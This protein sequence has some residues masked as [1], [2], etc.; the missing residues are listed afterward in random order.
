MANTRAA[1]STKACSTAIRPMGPRPTTAA[2]LPELISALR[3]P[4][5][6][7]AMPSVISRAWSLVTPS[8]IFAAL[9]S[10]A[11]TRTASACEP[12]SFDD[13]P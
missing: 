2:V 12:C 6:A 7:V 1:P 9:K 5:Q 8:G 13:R 11:G 10:P 4:Y 3:A